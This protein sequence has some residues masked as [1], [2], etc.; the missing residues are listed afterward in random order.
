MNQDVWSQTAERRRWL[1]DELAGLQLSE[2]E[3]ASWC[4]DWTLRD[5]LAHL[6]HLAETST[7][8]MTFE[9]AKT[10]F[11]FDRAFRRGVEQLRE[12]SPDAL[13]DRLRAAACGRFHVP[14][15]PAIVALGELFVH[16]ADMF[17]PLGRTYAVPGDDVRPLLP[18]FR[19]LG[20]VGYHAREVKQVRLV[21]T[22]TDWSAGKGSVVE[23]TALDLLLLM[24]NRR[25]VV[26]RLAGDGVAR[27]A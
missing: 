15:T 25:Q 19:R 26:P 8:A 4:A 5:V 9:I 1:A 20:R 23:G 27:F 18:V 10:G 21:A 11:V 14:G 22:D 13:C 16:P 17:E 6:V 3:T 7:P 2:W 12:V 24:A